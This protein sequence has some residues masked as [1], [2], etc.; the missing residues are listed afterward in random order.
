MIKI[1]FEISEDFVKTGADPQ[2]VA[3]KN[4]EGGVKKVT[5]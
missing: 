3:E 4:A 5:L 1:I 2:K